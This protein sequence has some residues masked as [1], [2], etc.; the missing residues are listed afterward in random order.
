VKKLLILSANPHN[1]E[2][3]R[4]DEEVREIQ[5]ALERSRD[6]DQFEI[7][8][9]LALPVGDL[10]HELLNC[11][12]Q[13]VHFCGHGLGSGGL[14]LE[15]QS[16]QRQSVGTEALAQLFQPLTHQIECVVLNLC[17]SNVQAVAI[18]QYINCVIGMKTP[19]GDRAA[20]HFA[21][22]FYTA[23]GSGRSYADAYHFG[24]HGIGLQ[25]LPGTYTPVLLNRPGLPIP[26]APV[27]DREAAPHPSHPTP[28]IVMTAG[29]H[30]K[31]IGSIGSISTLNL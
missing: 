3:L 23:L 29:D 20:I 17:D 21:K 30:A 27:A 12:P 24:C 5:V 1:T 2:H 16:G 28:T 11:Q 13:I 18:H 4:L 9:R 8:T 26:V 14:L 10:I 31:Q 15:D 25:G 6:R 19:I 22:G 7:I